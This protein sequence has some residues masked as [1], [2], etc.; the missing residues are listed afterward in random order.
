M[1][2]IFSICAY[3][4]E[5]GT[6]YDAVMNKVSFVKKTE[7]PENIDPKVDNPGLALPPAENE[8]AADQATIWDGTATNEEEEE[9][10]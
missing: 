7:E 1:C 10:E 5:D 9:Q 8:G 3:I 4:A 2:R 6:V